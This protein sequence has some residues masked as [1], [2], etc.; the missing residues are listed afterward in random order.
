MGSFHS[1]HPEKA[2]HMAQQDLITPEFWDRLRDAFRTSDALHA[3]LHRPNR[4]LDGGTPA[5]TIET[6]QT[7]EV[8]IVLRALDSQP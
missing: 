1:P 3:G 7:E 6:G 2:A 4:F 8:L 5:E